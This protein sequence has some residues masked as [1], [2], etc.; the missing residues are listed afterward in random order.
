MRDLNFISPGD[1]RLLDRKARALHDGA[2]AASAGVDELFRKLSFQEIRQCE[3]GVF[4]DDFSD[5]VNDMGAVHHGIHV[6]D[7]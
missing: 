3:T 2:E 7:V 6:A 4:V 5:P 1:Q